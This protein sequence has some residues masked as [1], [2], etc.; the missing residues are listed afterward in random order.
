MVKCARTLIFLLLIGNVKAKHIVP[1]NR[2]IIHNT[3]EN[4]KAYMT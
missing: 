2:H 3:D 1:K 4:K